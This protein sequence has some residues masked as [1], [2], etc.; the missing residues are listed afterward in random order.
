MKPLVYTYEN[1]D[2]QTVCFRGYFKSYHGTG[3][4]VH[5]CPEVRGNKFKALDDAKKALVK[6]KKDLLKQTI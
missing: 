2:K 3:V 4:Q 5:T 6:Y 1:S